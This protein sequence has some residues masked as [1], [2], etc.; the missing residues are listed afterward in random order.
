MTFLILRSAVQ[1]AVILFVVLAQIACRTNP[2]LTTE[3]A[4][5]LIAHNPEFNRS[6]ELVSVDSLANGANSY[7]TDCAGQFRF[8]VRGSPVSSS[9]I[10]AT[11]SFRYWNGRW[12]LTR[13][14][15]GEFPS[16][17][18][19]NVDPGEDRP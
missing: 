12:H 15:Y 3:A 18:D 5:A 11:A 13:Y 6:L 4:A 1:T 10:S 7:S 19:V 14:W 9:A 2:P 17:T 16:L 8:R